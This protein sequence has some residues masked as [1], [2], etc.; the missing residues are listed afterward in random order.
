MK[1]KQAEMIPETKPET[2]HELKGWDSVAHS[3]GWFIMV[4]CCLAVFVAFMMALCGGFDF[5]IHHDRASIIQLDDQMDKFS[6]TLWDVLHDSMES[7]RRLYD[8]NSLLNARI[9]ENNSYIGA[10]QVHIGELSDRLKK[11]ENPPTPAQPFFWPPNGLV[12]SNIPCWSLS[13]PNSIS[14]MPCVTNVFYG[15]IE[16]FQTNSC[17]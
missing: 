17:Q 12:V 6:Q 15:H 9:D 11:L 8:T 3:L 13:A 4:L 5:A 7:T 16:T 2:Y 1:T 10:L 14:A